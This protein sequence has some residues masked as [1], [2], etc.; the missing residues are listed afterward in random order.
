MLQFTIEIIS[1]SLIWFGIYFF[2]YL[3][4]QKYRLKKDVNLKS[5]TNIKP[6][7]I[8]FIKRI[9]K[10]LLVLILI[11]ASFDIYQNRIN[12]AVM[13]QIEISNG[14][15]TLKFQEMAHMGSP[16]FYKTIVDDIKYNKERGYVLYFEW[17]KLSKD[18]IKEDKFNSLMGIQFSKSTYKELKTIYG[19][20]NQNN[21]DFLGLVN[22]KDYQVDVTIEDVINKY[23][24]V[25]GT[26]TIDKNAK[27]IDVWTTIWDFTKEFKPLLPVIRTYN[28]AI[29]NFTIKNS[30]FRQ[31]LVKLINKSNF[32][33]VIINYR[34]ESLAEEVVKRKD[35]KIF[36]IYGMEH[37]KSFFNHLNK[38]DPDKWKIISNKEIQ[39]ID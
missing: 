35:K 28:R 19:L 2:L 7:L 33:D 12:P 15:Q 4:Y 34:S 39:L 24:K 1:F 16:S 37:F 27:P 20:E 36:V 6:Y 8:K 9:L 11:V 32:F 30:L 22:N 3:A 26:I 13:N 23:E 31:N 38:I 18:K 17:V 29:I 21:N 14:S 5:W 10:L 25:Y